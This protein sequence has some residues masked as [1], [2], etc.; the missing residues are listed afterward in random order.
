VRLSPQFNRLV[1]WPEPR[2]TATLDEFLALAR[3][4]DRGRIEEALRRIAAEGGSYRL[5][6]AFTRADGSARVFWSEGFWHD[7][8]GG[9][10]AEIVAFCQDVTER[11]TFDERMLQ[12]QK[13][14]AIG[15]LTGGVAHDFNNLLTVLMGGSELLVERLKDDPPLARQAELMLGA[16][17]RGAE[18]T[19]RLLAFARR[20][21]L[22]PEATDAN[23]LL[24]GL[25]GLLRRSLG[26]HIEI[27]LVR[28]A[29]LWP[30]L[31][32]RPQLETAILNLAINARDAMPKGGRL[33]IETANAHIDRDYADALG[34]VAP[35]QYVMVAVAD[36]GTGM[37]PDIAARAFEPFFTTKETGK[38]TGLGLSMVYGF[39][40]QS[41]GHAKIYSELGKG[42][43]VKLYLPRAAGDA[44]A[45]A[46]ARTET[47]AAA[48]GSERIL[49]VE[50]DE[51]VRDF[52]ERRLRSMGYAVTAAESAPA[53]LARL[54]R[55]SFDLLFTDIVMPG[56]MHGPELAEAAR[57]VQPGLKVLFT[58]GYAENAAIHHGH[59]P[60]GAGLLQKPYRLA[61]LA[62]KI[63][64]AL[65][66]NGG[67]RR[68]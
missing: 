6:F 33:T 37:P 2:E 28:A 22:A 1:G 59:L 23:R 39:A 48:A 35:G 36:T 9:G 40:K 19:Q 16:A 56:G 11:R 10:P 12:T 20:Q 25:D 57:R 8:S 60:A 14:E 24:T 65:D 13:M 26:E 34:D 46:D 4:R 67:Q 64:A 38:G 5:E 32:D 50:D 18:L 68:G 53:A 66:G 7:G 17:Q 61:D 3:D 51:S 55:E 29:G 44:G 52:A 54:E 58:S 31:V 30:A 47:R 21:P 43:T 63:R 49:L 41:G 15:Q 45:R 27:E 62:T 42:T